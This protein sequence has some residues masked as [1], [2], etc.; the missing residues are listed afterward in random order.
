M[1]N[2]VTI[3]GR[4][5][6]SVEV[7]RTQSGKSVTSFSLAVDRDFKNSDGTREAD[8]I[9]CVAWGATAEYLGKYA[10]KGRM[11]AVT[12]RLQVREWQ[13]QDKQNRKVMEVIASN[14]YFTDS[15]PTNGLNQGG[16][17]AQTGYGAAPQYGAGYGVQSNTNAPAQ[18]WRNE[19]GEDLPF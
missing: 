17:G 3:V 11:L 5:G 9:P 16:Y 18:E 13:D 19:Q 2:S 8:W 15:K 6:K 12:G 1:L 14:V 7:R 10:S 4:L